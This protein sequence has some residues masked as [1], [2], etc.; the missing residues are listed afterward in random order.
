MVL[1]VKHRPL[2][3]QDALFNVEQYNYINYLATRKNIPHVVITGRVGSGKNTL[4]RHFIKE[5]YGGVGNIHEKKY[6]VPNS[7]GEVT[8]VSVEQSEHYIVIVPTSNNFDRYI[9][10]T[11]IKEYVQVGCVDFF[12][13]QRGFKT[14]MIMNT[15]TLSHPS[16]SILRCVMEDYVE[17]CRFIFVCN[18]LSKIIDPVRSRCTLINMHPPSQQ[19]LEKLVDRVCLLENIHIKYEEK[20]VMIRCARASSPDTTGVNEVFW[21]LEARK[22]GVPDNSDG[23]EELAEELLESVT[24]SVKSVLNSQVE[25]AG[26]QIL[27]IFN[28]SPTANVQD[29]KDAIFSNLYQVGKF[30]SFISHY[31]QDSSTRCVLSLELPMHSYTTCTELSVVNSIDFAVDYLCN[32]NHIN[33]FITLCD[34]HIWSGVTSIIATMY[35]ASRVLNYLCHRLTERIGKPQLCSKLWEEA[36]RIDFN[37]CWARRKVII[38]TNAYISHAMKMIMDDGGVY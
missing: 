2:C 1:V 26:H 22:R 20:Q 18:D 14:V 33:K 10:E 21:Q 31:R 13:K 27:C 24:C 6:N 3:A 35:D 38:H 16:Q 23:L 12:K 29:F 32:F 34:R 19:E 7:S 28:I 15:E 25:K 17:Y 30:K 4:A 8:P 9:L 11:I 37:I 5:I 36:A